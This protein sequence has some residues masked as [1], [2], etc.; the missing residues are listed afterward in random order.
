VGVCFS[1]VTQRG[2]V[3]MLACDGN[4]S[5]DVQTPKIGDLGH[6]ASRF[7]RMVDT[8]TRGSSAA[9]SEDLGQHGVTR[10]GPAARPGLKE[11]G[12]NICGSRDVCIHWALNRHE[13]HSADSG[14]P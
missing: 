3:P 13:N 9:H 10:V 4:Y 14:Q 12:R 6:T 7:R 2:I 1:V 11:S 8:A 5:P